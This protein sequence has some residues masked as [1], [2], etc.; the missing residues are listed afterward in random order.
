MQKTGTELTY[1]CPIYLCNL[2]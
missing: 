1:L 2:R